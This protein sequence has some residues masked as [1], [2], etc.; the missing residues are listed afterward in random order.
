VRIPNSD[1]CAR[2]RLIRPP[3]RRTPSRS[4]KE[5]LDDIIVVES[6]ILL[7][8]QQV[9]NLPTEIR[10]DL[11][12]AWEKRLKLNPQRH[13]R[14]GKGRDHLAGE[15]CPFP[16]SPLCVLCSAKGQNRAIRARFSLLLSSP[17]SSRLCGSRGARILVAAPLLQALCGWRTPADG[18]KDSGKG[19]CRR[20]RGFR[21]SRVSGPGGCWTL[22]LPNGHDLAQRRVS[23]VRSG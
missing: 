19:G 8:D 20:C 3:K 9:D 6:K 2:P 4:Q 7:A 21:R 15:G 1:S 5:V 11:A 12:H 16:G 14:S 22:L 10:F 18:I 17:R 13:R 23:I